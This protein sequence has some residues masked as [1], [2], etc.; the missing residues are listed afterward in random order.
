[1]DPKTI[2][3][4]TCHVISKVAGTTFTGR[5]EITHH[6]PMLFIVAPEEPYDPGPVR[7]LVAALQS[8]LKD[9]K[10]IEASE[11]GP[12][13]I[14][15]TDAEGKKVT[16]A[17]DA[18]P[19]IDLNLESYVRMSILPKEFQDKIREHLKVVMDGQV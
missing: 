3:L 2:N 4:A 9:P 18:L 14:E 12:A 15:G 1:M 11:D 19:Q 13:R 10:L 5:I 6:Q 17:V 8:D 7:E 16:I